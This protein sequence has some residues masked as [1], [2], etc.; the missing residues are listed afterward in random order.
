MSLE[1]ILQI[2]TDDIMSLAELKEDPMFS[3][4]SKKE[5]LYYIRESQR[6]ATERAKTL[7]EE[8]IYENLI[9]IC[10]IKGIQVNI[11]NKDC[12]FMDIKY[13]AEIYYRKSE[14]NIIRP[15]IELMFNELKNNNLN[16]YKDKTLVIEDVI[17]IH[18]AH[19]LYHLLE[20]NEQKDTSYLLNPITEL[21]IFNFKK[22]RR[23]LKV[24]EIAAHKFCKEYL[25]M[26]FHPKVLDYL[27]L[28]GR[29]ELNEKVFLNY[30]YEL[31]NELQ[32]E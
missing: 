31:R 2:S 29:G 25:D 16:I 4:M 27:Y 11:C 14:I 6:I 7:K 17:D 12:K 13:R 8:F 24:S 19:E 23:V 26:T 30:I 32:G 21:K 20:Y 15:S 22:V 5:I 1:E 28:I 10:N 18:L 9:D 3:I